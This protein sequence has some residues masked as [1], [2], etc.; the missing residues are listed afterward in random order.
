MAAVYAIFG[1]R[2]I[3]VKRTQL[4]L[5]CFGASLL[6]PIGFMVVGSLGTVSGILSSWL[7]VA[8]FSDIC[9]KLYSEPLLTFIASVI[10]VLWVVYL[11]K[12]RFSVAILLGLAVGFSILSKGIFCS[13]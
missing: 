9:G 3:M 6:I 12:P 5:F 10:L 4:L 13:T 7:F 1:I 8:S 11:K 2:P